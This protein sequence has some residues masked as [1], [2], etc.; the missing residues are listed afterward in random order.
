MTKVTPSNDFTRVFRRQLLTV[1][2]LRGSRFQKRFQ[3]GSRKIVQNF[4]G[5][6]TTADEFRPTITCAA[7]LLIVLINVRRAEEYQT[8]A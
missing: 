1:P 6:R 4:R 3:F 2:S 5:F 7:D 8:N